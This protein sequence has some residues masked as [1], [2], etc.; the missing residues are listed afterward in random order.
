VSPRTGL[1]VLEKRKISSPY[2]ELNNSLPST[3][4]LH[5][6]IDHAVLALSFLTK[7]GKNVHVVEVKVLTAAENGSTHKTPAAVTK[8]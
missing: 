6:Y 4:Q 3:P 5:H 1:V 2:W 8:I 7:E